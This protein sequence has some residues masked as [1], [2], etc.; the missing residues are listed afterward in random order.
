MIGEVTFGVPRYYD[1]FFVWCLLEWWKNFSFS[2]WVGGKKIKFF[3]GSAE[4]KNLL[5]FKK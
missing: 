5:L 4:R 1:A 3:W 2:E